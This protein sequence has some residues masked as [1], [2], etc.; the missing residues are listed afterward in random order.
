MK[1][2]HQPK[3]TKLRRK[4]TR[5]VG[6]SY[7]LLVLWQKVLPSHVFQVQATTEYSL[8]SDWKTYIQFRPKI[9]HILCS[10]LPYSGR[11]YFTIHSDSRICFVVGRFSGLN[12]SIGRS[13]SKKASFSFASN[14]GMP[15][16]RL[17]CCTLSSNR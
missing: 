4:T 7:L 15:L 5:D 16:S 11:A 17:G 1:R 2:C 3:S 8:G 13:M 12:E 6:I 9:T 10:F 14:E